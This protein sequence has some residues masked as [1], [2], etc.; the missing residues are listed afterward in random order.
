MSDEGMKI[1]IKVNR[2]VEKYHEGV[3]QEDIESGIAKPYEVVD[4][5][6][7]EEMSEEKAREMG[8]IN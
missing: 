8:L 6:E 2:K 4:F 5:D 3:S 1:K 7:Y